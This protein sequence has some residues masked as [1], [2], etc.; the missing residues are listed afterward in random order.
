METCLILLKLL[1]FETTG[2]S[3][4]SKLTQPPA[5]SV[6][7]LVTECWSCYE[8]NTSCHCG[9]GYI[10]TSRHQIPFLG[11]SSC[12]LEGL[13]HQ[14]YLLLS[15]RTASSCHIPQP[16]LQLACDTWQFYQWI[17][18]KSDYANFR[19]Q[20]SHVWFSTFFSLSWCDER[21]PVT[22]EAVHGKWTNYKMGV[23][24]ISEGQ[25]GGMPPI[26]H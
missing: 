25:P 8:K 23:I 13:F 10:Q 3:P 21:S 18:S 15:W 5:F 24:W 20:S 6:S 16:S 11:R 1:S 7:S 4:N 2:E 26:A 17:V 22:M 19:S 12:F 14:T 9:I